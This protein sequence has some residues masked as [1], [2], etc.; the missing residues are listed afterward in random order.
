MRVAVQIDRLFADLV[1]GSE[2]IMAQDEV[3]SLVPEFRVM[4]HAF[5]SRRVRGRR[6]VVVADDQVLST[7]QPR[8][9]LCTVA[10]SCRDEVS[11]MPDLVVGPDGLVPVPDQGVVVFDHVEERTSVEAKDARVAE[12]GIAGEIDHL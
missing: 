4:L 5:P 3:I 9:Q 7:V 2:S 12:M 10:C 8:K 1:P 11:Q 6:R